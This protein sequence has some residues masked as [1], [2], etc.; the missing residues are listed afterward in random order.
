MVVRTKPRSIHTSL[1]RLVFVLR[2]SSR[3]V[4]WGDMMF[5]V[6]ETKDRKGISWGASASLR[7][8]LF[9]TSAADSAPHQ[10]RNA[11][12]KDASQPRSCGNGGKQAGE[13][14]PHANH[15]AIRSALFRLP[16]PCWLLFL[17]SIG[18]F[19]RWE[20][21]GCWSTATAYLAATALPSTRE[22]VWPLFKHHQRRED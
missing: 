4:H 2:G 14:M 9:L 8:T 3:P 12:P 7:L 15:K 21:T 20:T 16:N 19:I 11:D 6:G 18:L 10:L 17:S 5:L 22:T 1:V 13:F